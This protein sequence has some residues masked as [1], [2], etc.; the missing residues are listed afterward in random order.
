MTQDNIIVNKEDYMLSDNKKYALV[1]NTKA[2]PSAVFKF[3]KL[4]K[5]YFKGIKAVAYLR[6]PSRQYIVYFKA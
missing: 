1:T 6:G 2:Y 4:K 3:L 5:S